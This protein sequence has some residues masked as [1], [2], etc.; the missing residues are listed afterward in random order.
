MEDQKIELTYEALWKSII[1]PPKDDYTEAM[2]GDN[3][4]VYRGKT[5]IRRDYNVLNKRGDFMR[6][7][8][9]EPEEDSRV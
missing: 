4:F 7:S 8:F 5:Y 2:L 3:I 6:C 1:R 9:I